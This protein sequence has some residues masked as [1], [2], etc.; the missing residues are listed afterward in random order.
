MEFGINISGKLP[1]SEQIEGMKKAG[2]FRTF[3]AANGHDF[4]ELMAELA[5]NGIICDNMHAPFDGINDMWHEGETGEDMLNRLK[6]SVD[7]CKQYAVPVLVVHLSAG[8]PMKAISEIGMRRFAGLVEYANA[9]G[10]TI[11]F[12]NQRYLENLKWSLED[13]PG[14]GFCWDCG[15]EACFTP[16]LKF[17]PYF[18]DKLVALHIHDNSCEY[19]VDNHV[20]P[21]DGKMDFDYVAKEI[22]KSGYQGTLMLETSKLSQYEGKGIYEEMTYEEF[23][24]RAAES[25]KKLRE[26]IEKYRSAG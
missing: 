20:L 1:Y 6:I 2:I 10:V 22:A 13:C 24:Q 23:Y 19:N 9:N 17:M 4:D 8:C 14:A 12:E 5:A 11:A 26:L 16:G 7:R 3:V 21:F 25:L 15:H 18:A